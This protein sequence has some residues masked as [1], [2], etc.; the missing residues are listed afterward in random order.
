MKKMLTGF[1]FA[2][3][4]YVILSSCD[5]I[6]EI[7]DQFGQV[8]IVKLTASME[9][10]METFQKVHKIMSSLHDDEEE[11]E[12]KQENKCSMGFHT[13]AIGELITTQELEEDNDD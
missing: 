4:G 12:E 8:L 11:E 3:M 10:H 7:I 6:C 2:V 9:P 13:E 5:T 1:G